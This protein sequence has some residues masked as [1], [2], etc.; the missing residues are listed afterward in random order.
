MELCVYGA[1]SQNIDP[2]YLQAGYRLGTVLADR[3]HGLIFGGGDTG[4]MGAVVRGALAH[5]GRAVGVA[6]HF[7]DR[8]GVL[9]QGCEILF[10]D[11]MRQRKEL[12]EQRADAF[13]MAP[14]GIGTLEEFFE[15]LTLKQLGRHRKPIGILNTAGCYDELLTFLAGLVTRG[16]MA[17]SCLALYESDPSP[18]ILLDRLEGV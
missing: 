16:F 8:D 4:L 10:T 18:E 1:S 2:V 7:F 5:G 17:A 13:I 3:G 9:Y 12:M 14:G 6:P 11:T 15:I